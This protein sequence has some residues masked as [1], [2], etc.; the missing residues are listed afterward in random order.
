MDLLL[1][2][3]ESINDGGSTFQGFCKKNS[4]GENPKVSSRQIRNYPKVIYLHE[5]C[6][7]E[8]IDGDTEAVVNNLEF[9]KITTG[10]TTE[11]MQV[12]F[13]WMDKEV[14]GHIQ[15]VVVNSS[16]SQWT[17][18]TSGVPQRPLS[19]TLLLTIF[20][21]DRDEGFKCI[22]IKFAGDTKMSGGV[23]RPKDRIPSRG[24]A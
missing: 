3:A 17:S 8:L 20:I 21:D 4:K 6:Y 9:T 23:D 11:R 18:V 15:R 19:G 16:E 24:Q 14:D 22:L 10:K 7:P 1:A 12:I 2:K 5:N 13:V